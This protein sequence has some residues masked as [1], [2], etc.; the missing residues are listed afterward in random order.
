MPTN[1]TTSVIEYL[2]RAVLLRDGAGLGDGELLG[3]FIDR[4]DE[5]ALAA[6]VKRHGSM[7]WGVC[8]RLLS[9]HDAEDAFQATFIVL[10]RKAASIVPREK[11]GNWLYGVAHQ[12]AL[13]ARRTAA[14][15][16]AREVQVTEMPDTEAVQQDQWPDVR[17]L[18]D[19]ELSRLP[20][21]YRAVIVLCDLEGRTRKEVARQLGIPE[22]TVAGRLAR[23]RAMLAKRLTQRGVTLSGGALAAVLAQ[24]VASASVSISL[25]S[26]TIQ[27]A[28]LV[29]VGQ[30]AATGAISVKVA[31]LTEGVL[32]AMLMSKL[33]AVIAIVLVLGLM[34]TGA[35]V[36]TCRTA[37]AQSDKPPTA[38]ERVKVPPKQEQEKEKESFTAWGKEVGGLQAGLGYHPGQKR[39]Y[40]HG[41]TVTLVVR[42]RNVGKEEVK[43]HYFSEE[44]YEDPPTVVNGDG[45]PV[46]FKRPTAFGWIEPI[47]ASLAPGKEV[48][49]CKLNLQIRPAGEKGK[50]DPWTLYETGKYQIQYQKV[51]GY[52]L[53]QE[54]KA[55]PILSKLATGKLELEV[56]EAE[57]PP[58]KQEKEAFTAWGKEV[59]GLQAG[60]GFHPGQQR[61]Y[62]HGETV[63]LVVRVRNVG[64]EE[65]KFQYLRQ[66][67]IEI[68]PA[69]TDGEGKPVALPRVTALGI[70]IPVEVNLAPGKEIELYEL[71]RELRPASESGNE[72]STLYGTGKFQI[73]YERLA[74]ADIDKILGKLA[75]GKLELEIKSDPPAA[76]EKKPLTVSQPVQRKVAPSEDFTGRLV[77]VGT[78]G[79]RALPDKPIAVRFDMDE[80][81]Y[82]RYQ[83]LLSKGQVKGAGD[84]LAVGLSDE[85][86]F[87]RAGTLDHFD[88]E[89]KPATGAIGVHGVLPNADG[90]LLPG[91][92]V[93]VRMT[94]GPPRPVLEV[95]EEAV[96][97]EQGQPYVWV[98]SD[99]N[100]VERR[101]VRPGAMDGGMRI[102]EEG[103]RP[104]DRVISAGA[105]GLKPGDHVE[106]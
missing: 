13:Q 28:T 41:E 19:Q 63:T 88:N 43:F 37:T 23:A 101:E 31:A 99:G 104:E 54:I 45:K 53:S 35:T 1:P 72:F 40:S 85:N 58:E 39:A 87:P 29:A 51:G 12:T 66:F 55:N 57:K 18:L 100:I 84:A 105:Q 93:R 56:K 73:Q 11:V 17:P 91:M 74:S 36:L 26:A 70:H 81:S 16:R 9:H 69:V 34:A 75:T 65:V 15:R 32:K 67:F 82:L 25:V 8:R 61:A 86:S 83:R 24:N 52:L 71:K 78:G 90:L 102:I 59:G 21:N 77:A 2:R 47:E 64:K 60:L 7:V 14:R 49:L 103:L 76:T 89:F 97:R 42:V 98:V 44:C 94:F 33:K 62:S 92:F 20:D 38:E 30:T 95:P 22:G 79:F 80:S 4:H 27:A 96:G 106:R 50:D 6:L 5:A 68:P 48:E 10:V 3:G 46:T